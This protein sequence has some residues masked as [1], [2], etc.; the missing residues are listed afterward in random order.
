MNKTC[1]YRL[2]VLTPFPNCYSIVTAQ[3]LGPRAEGMPDGQK[4]YQLRWPQE[5]NHTSTSYKIWKSSYS[6]LPSNAYPLAVHM[7]SPLRFDGYISFLR[8]R[9]WATLPSCPHRAGAEI[10]AK[11]LKGRREWFGPD[12]E[13][14]PCLVQALCKPVLSPAY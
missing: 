7:C 12:T 11:Q 9:E 13:K 5:C 8:W 2:R 6:Y 4:E 14:N 3:G 10:I 1:P